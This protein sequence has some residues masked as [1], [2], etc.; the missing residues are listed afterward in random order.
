MN[1]DSLVIIGFVAVVGVSLLIARWSLRR[2][3]KEQTNWKSLSGFAFIVVLGVVYTWVIVPLYA[4]M[5]ALKLFAA[6]GG[7]A[8]IVT[9][10][11]GTALIMEF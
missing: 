2:F 5:L 8:L 11:I 7:L 9:V 3:D 1:Q 4:P 6:V 10:S